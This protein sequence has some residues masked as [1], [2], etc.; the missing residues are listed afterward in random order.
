HESARDGTQHLDRGASAR[1]QPAA[2]DRDKHV[3]NRGQI[4]GDLKADGALPGDDVG[5]VDRRHK[6]TACGRSHLG[7]ALL[8]LSR[9]AQHHLRAVTSRRGHLDVRRLLR[10]DDVCGHAIDG[11]RIGDRLCVIAARVGHHTAGPHGLVNVSDGVEGAPNLERADRLRVLGLDPERPM[12]VGPACGDHGG[13]QDVG[14]YQF[15]GGA[16]VVDAYQLH[17]CSLPDQWAV[18]VEYWYSISGSR[19]FFVRTDTDPSGCT[20]NSLPHLKNGM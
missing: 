7:G 20:W 18:T 8:A 9:T 2:T 17:K 16:D 15:R 11:R 10:H 12:V 3:F 1:C 13:A 14:T 19:L 6:H 5:V 4:L